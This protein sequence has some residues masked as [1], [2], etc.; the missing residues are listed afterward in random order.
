MVSGTGGG[1]SPARSLQPVPPPAQAPPA[2]DRVPPQNLDAEVSVLGSML[3]SKNAIAEVSEIL[4][5]EDFYRGAHR[6]MF[7]A[8]IGLYDRGEPVDLVTLGDALRRTGQLE[9]VGGDVALVEITERVPT[10][11]NALYY[12]RIVADHAL[13]RRLIEAGTDITRLGYDAEGADEAVDGAEQRIYDV[14]QRTRVSEFTPMKELLNASFERIERLHENSSAIT[15][16]GTGFHDFDEL[17]AGL[18]PGNLVVLAA[19]PGIGK[20]TLVMNIATNVAVDQRRPV[21][22]FSLEMSQME[23]V[24]RVLSGHARVDLG[25]LKT[26]SLQETDWPKLS[27][28]MGRL[29]E[30][31]LFIDDT[32]DINLLEIRSKC[33]RLKQ[34]FGLELIVVDYLQLMQSHR[35]TENRVQEVSELSRGMKVLAK[36]LNVP[37]IALSQLSRKPEDRTDRRPQLSDLRE[38]GCLTSDTRVL[39][40]DTNAEVTLGELVA[41]GERNIPVWTVNAD[42]KLVR[43]TMTHAFP[44]GTKDVFRLRLASGRE[45]KASANHPFLT[46]DGWRRLDELAV[47]DRI[48]VP[49][50]IGEPAQ[51]TQWADEQ[52]ILLAHLIGD[53]CFA[54]GQ[55][56][57]Y[58]SADPANLD[59][60]E[61]AARHFGVTARRVQQDTWWHL[62]LPAPY[63]LTWGKRNPIVAWLDELGLYG[64]RSREK[65]IPAPVFG[66]PRRQ[67]ALFLRHLW[68]TDGSVTR[69]RRDVRLY[70]ASGSRALLEDLQVLLLRFEITATIRSS[71]KAGYDA[72]FSLDIESALPQLRFL[73]EIGVHGRRG[74]QARAQ[75][76]FLRTVRPAP[77]RDTVPVEVWEQVTQRRLAKGMS[78][79]ALTRKAG[80]PPQQLAVAAPT[81]ARLL[82]IATALEDDH[83]AKLAT[84]DLY[85]DRIVAVDAIGPTEVF[86]ATVLGTHNFIANNIIVENSIEQDSDIVLFIYRDEVYN[87]ETEAKGEAELIVAKHR[88]GPLRTVRLSFLAHH[89][90]FASM[91]RG[92]MPPGR[93]GI[94]PGGG[95]APL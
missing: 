64:K 36:E 80:L 85:W 2:Y 62:Y 37:V 82:T 39:R 50:V 74:E 18:Q 40:A 63:R 34:K 14:A 26:G 24:D 84:T 94:A 61:A 68:A 87:P 33:R 73:D 22:F 32:S 79:L 81:R 67:L 49:R 90:R 66:L 76:S 41:S 9:G 56:L 11:A 8:M 75:A 13:R 92:A 25:R 58:T 21:A 71:R 7:E 72:M 55:P 45:V 65:F 15:G 57:H 27:Q 77:K 86:D 47:G 23:L 51:T 35:R 91:A 1:N 10:A 48:A 78:N 53:G 42:Y 46:L 19:R 30:A 38:S 88:N 69:W 93:G 28:A 16:L 43:G 20:S 31:P 29:A 70:F 5:P 6:T 52:V 89:S 83:L 17:T 3:L 44:S 54:S 12:A 95:G 60:V 59:A 4:G